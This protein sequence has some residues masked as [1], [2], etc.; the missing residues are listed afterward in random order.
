[1]GVSEPYQAFI[2]ESERS[3]SGTETPSVIAPAGA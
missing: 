1:M 3:S 2:N